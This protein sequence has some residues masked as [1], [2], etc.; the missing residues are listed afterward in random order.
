MKEKV[1]YGIVGVLVI[2]IIIMGVFMLTNK[3]NQ[4]SNNI[5]NSRDGRI[6]TGN[7]EIDLPDAT[8][9]VLE[10][11]TVRYT[12]PDG[13]SVTEKSNPD[14]SVTRNKNGSEPLM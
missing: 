7:P 12:N 4:T 9:E 13:T 8:R 11:G 1:L 5:P 3:N 10:D 2:A 6:M 14:G